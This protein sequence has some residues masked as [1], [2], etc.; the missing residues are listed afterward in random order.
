M[1][2]S[3]GVLANDAAVDATIQPINAYNIDL[4][5]QGIAAGKEK[6]KRKEKNVALHRLLMKNCTKAFG[7]EEKK[8]KLSCPPGAQK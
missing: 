7:R 6:K 8:K 2:A 5:F 4:H 3:I 1:I